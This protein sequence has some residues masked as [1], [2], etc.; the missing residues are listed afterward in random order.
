MSFNRLRLHEAIDRMGARLEAPRSSADLSRDGASAVVEAARLA[1][2]LA[3][4]AGGRSFG[5]AEHLREVKIPMLFL[6]GTRDELGLGR[7]L[8]TPCAR[9][10]VQACTSSARYTSPRNAH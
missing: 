3:L 2:K 1:P 10:S 7:G 6:Q 8:A 4:F 9:R 5:G